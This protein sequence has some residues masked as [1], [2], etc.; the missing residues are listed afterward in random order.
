M[1]LLLI[2]YD[3]SI[4]MDDDK[5]KISTRERVQRLFN[6][7]C[8]EQLFSLE[9]KNKDD[10]GEFQ[11]T[12][13]TI[14]D[15]SVNSRNIDLPYSADLPCI[16]VG[17][18]KR[19]TYF[20]IELCLVERRP[21]KQLTL[22]GVVPVSIEQ[23]WRLDKTKFYVVGAGIFTGLI[24]ALYPI[25]VVKPRKQV[26]A[27]IETEIAVFSD[28]VQG[29]LAITRIH[30]ANEDSESHYNGKLAEDLFA[31]DS[32]QPNLPSKEERN[33][34]L[35]TTEASPQPEIQIKY[36]RT[37]S[38][39][40]QSPRSE[41]PKAAIL[42]RI[43]SK[44]AAVLWN[45]FNKRE[46]QC[47]LVFGIISLGFEPKHKFSHRETDADITVAALSMDQKHATAF[48]LMKIDEEG[49]IIEFAE[50]PKEEQLKAMKV[51]TT[52]LG[53]DNERAKK[54]PYI[55]SMGIYVVRKDVIIN[56]LRDQFPGAPTFLHLSDVRNGYYI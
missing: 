13:V 26:G 47:I 46:A 20:P 27:Q 19:P 23:R 37:L 49:R 4:L 22:G 42:Q 34:I 54:M 12:E 10:A 43:D 36:K 55:A 51:H 56:L 52:I 5:K 28:N 14:Y 40:L 11:T 24:V 44:T 32:I 38:G 7:A 33:L 18:P 9:Q 41:V 25:S 15:Y 8:K 16:N 35:E 30:K 39:G 17:K 45:P 1:L 50:K 31:S 48:G 53:L 3:S 21:F 2:D 29:K 6:K